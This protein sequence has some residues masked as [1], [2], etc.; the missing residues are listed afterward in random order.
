MSV[1][2]VGPHLFDA[3][4]SGEHPGK[5]RWV[6]AGHV[7]RSALRGAMIWGAVFGL[8]VIST[9]E[10]FVRGYPTRDERLQLAHSL[11]SFAPLLGLPRHAETVAGFTAWRVLVAIAVI[12]AI[13]GL[14]TSTSLLR[15]EEEAGRWELL[16]AGPT[17][18][19]GAAGQA[20]LGL[21]GVLA[22]MFAV[23]ALLTLVAGHLPGARFSIGGSLLFAVALVSGAAMFLAVGALASQ[24]S[25]TR[26]QA[27]TIAASAL[28]ASYVVRMVADS[29]NSLG[30][31]RWLSP[32]GWIEELRPLQDPQPL[33]LTPILGLVLA[34]GGLA[35]LLAGRRD[36][37]ASVLRE[38]K[39]NLGGARWLIGPTTL[40]LRL[41]RPAGLAWLAG[42]AVMGVIYG[43]LVRS[44]G[45]I[46]TDSP[47]VTATLGRLGVRQATLGYL[48]IVFLFVDVLIAVLAASQVAAIRDE[49]A[50]G[51]LDNLLVRPVGRLTWLGG[52]LGVSL[53][54]IV[55]AGLVAGFCA[56]VGVASQHIYMARLT[57]IEAGVNAS[58]PAVFV[59]G[60]G[61][62][63]L[64]LRP[65]LSAAASYAIVAWSFLIDLLGSLLE[66]ARWLR[67]SSLFTHIALAPAAKP[68]WGTAAIIVL[69]G[70]VA[71][72][73]GA[74][75]F[76]RRDVEYT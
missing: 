64:G 20:L 5:L 11:R 75:A 57:M 60:A 47:S 55:L 43:S 29:R 34:S 45:S 18:K 9:I 69:L 14:L 63:V 36:L 46:L 31:L 25:A 66:G 24:L 7:V 28:G 2:G 16:L 40:A 22:V 74:V 12:G 13:W 68:D 48:G 1:T 51:R 30:W 58:V 23:T 21:G 53:S 15:G 52:R 3:A 50:A 32:I 10:A 41:S 49:E 54:L 70:V 39:A 44:A 17:T 42:L 65:R 33:A 4:R 35:V 37:G 38:G 73:I 76:Q 19:R 27:V 59:L 72:V 62:L 67:D 56:W 6:I 61:T 26:G 8:F 71:A